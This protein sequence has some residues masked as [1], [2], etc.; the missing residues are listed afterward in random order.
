MKN[1]KLWFENLE[2]K[3]SVFLDLDET[4]VKT[5]IVNTNEKTEPKDKKF[6]YNSD[7]YITIL[8]PHAVNF[9]NSLKQKANVYI[10]THGKQKFQ[11]KVIELHNLPIS[12]KHIF[13]RENYNKVPKLNNFILVDDLGLSTAGAQDKLNA[14]GSF[15]EYDKENFKYKPINNF[16][17]IKPFF[18]DPNDKELLNVLPKIL[19]R[20]NA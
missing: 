6:K 16:V 5:R 18:G 4:L 9:I 14:L 12:K 2:E 15:P 19:E 11:E 17:N 8:R 10:F 20:L 13:G 3:P 1:F 7:Y